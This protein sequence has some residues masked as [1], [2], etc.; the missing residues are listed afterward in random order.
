[1]LIPQLSLARG[2]CGILFYEKEPPKVVLLIAK[3]MLIAM[4]EIMQKES[5]Q[6]NTITNGDL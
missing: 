4:I 2:N 6:D 1:M 3:L 5:I